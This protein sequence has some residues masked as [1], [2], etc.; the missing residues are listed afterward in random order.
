[1]NLFLLGAYALAFSL[2]K[3][4]ASYSAT[5]RVLWGETLP[6]DDPA[7]NKQA[8]KAIGRP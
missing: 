3:I 2:E 7:Q 8:Q 6:M 4:L 5:D 1:L